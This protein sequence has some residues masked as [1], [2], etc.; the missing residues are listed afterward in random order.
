MNLNYI[1]G[2]DYS[3]GS[4]SYLQKT[5]NLNFI[6]EGKANENIP[7]EIKEKYFNAEIDEMGKLIYLRPNGYMTEEDFKNDIA[8]KISSVEYD[9]ILKNKK[10]N[11]I[12][13]CEKYEGAKNLYESSN[14]ACLTNEQKQ[15]IIQTHAE[16]NWI[17][18]IPAFEVKLLTKSIGVN[19][20]KKLTQYIFCTGEEKEF[21]L[22]GYKSMVLDTLPF[23]TSA[24]KMYKKIGFYEIEQYN[25]SPM[26]DAIYM[27]MDL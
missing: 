7:N 12:P 17:Y 1:E 5:F 8:Q 26:Q 24:I 13:F 21:D 2:K 25:D 10:F 15:Y 18:K 27:K 14:F 23:L 3:I 4:Y 11:F 16:G 22:L 19:N 6:N 9:K 20:E